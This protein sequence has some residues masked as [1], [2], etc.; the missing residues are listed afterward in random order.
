MS[1]KICLHAIELRVYTISNRRV[2][3][4]DDLPDEHFG[5]DWMFSLFVV[6]YLECTEYRIEYAI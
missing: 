6:S 1:A 2:K 3:S 5:P 4:I